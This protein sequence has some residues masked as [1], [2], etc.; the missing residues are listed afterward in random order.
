MRAW[1]DAFGDTVAAA[2]AMYVHPNTFRYRLRRV[3]EVG[4]LD[5]HDPDARFAA[6]LELRLAARATSDRTGPP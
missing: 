4:P 3:T 5:L 6:M 1:L 2:A